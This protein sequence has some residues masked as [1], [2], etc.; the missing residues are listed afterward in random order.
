MIKLVTN[1]AEV[2]GFAYIER[3]VV[4]KNVPGGNRITLLRGIRIS[5]TSNL[6]VKRRSFLN[7]SQ[8]NNLSGFL[9]KYCDVAETLLAAV[10]M[11]SLMYGTTAI[12]IN[13]T[14]DEVVENFYS[15]FMGPALCFSEDGRKYF[16]MHGM[17]RWDILRKHFQKQINS[18]NQI[19]SKME[20]CALTPQNY[21]VELHPDNL[22]TKRMTGESTDSRK[23]QR[24]L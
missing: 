12:G 13:S 10:I 14:K 8:G 20:C 11:R 1:T 2:L 15:S 7:P 22:E 21:A 5:P 18:H 17:A 6:E 19:K 4:D 9:P 3:S 16:R 24:H 23:K